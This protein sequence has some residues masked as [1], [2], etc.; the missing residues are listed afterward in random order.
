MNGHLKAKKDVC[1]LW[2]DAHADLNT[3]ETSDSGNVH[4]MPMGLLAT[5]L[6][7]YWPYL[8]G[9]D[10]HTPM[11]SLKNVAYIGKCNLVNAL[12]CNNINKFFR[13]K[14]CRPL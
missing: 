10:W 5:E 12:L 1:V 14:K 4:G 7:D 6:S 3:N 11:L 13:F 2:I 9:M 8:P